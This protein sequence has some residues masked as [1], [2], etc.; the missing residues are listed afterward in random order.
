MYVGKTCCDN[1]LMSEW[2]NEY[3]VFIIMYLAIKFL[4][5]QGIVFQND[6]KCDNIWIGYF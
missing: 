6:E 1:N 3:L 4:K 2:V 5:T